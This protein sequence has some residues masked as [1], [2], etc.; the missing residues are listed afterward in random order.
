MKFKCASCKNWHWKI[1][2]RHITWPIDKW[3]CEKCYFENDIIE[4][5]QF[6][7]FQG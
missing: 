5:V 1:A 3:M 4:E 7:G 6:Q 2:Y